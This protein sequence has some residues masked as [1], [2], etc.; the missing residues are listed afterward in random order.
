MRSLQLQGLRKDKHSKE[1]IQKQ[2]Q[3]RIY[4]RFCMDVARDQHGR[5]DL[6]LFEHPA[7]ANLGKIVRCRECKIYRTC[8]KTCYRSMY[9][10]TEGPDE[11]T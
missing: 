11:W 1:W 5:G 3:A 7:F 4:L 9:V 8:R 6:F 10:W 2:A